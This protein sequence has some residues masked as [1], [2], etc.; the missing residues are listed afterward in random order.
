MATEYTGRR[1]A[2]VTKSDDTVLGQT[3]GLYVGGGDVVVR[4]TATGTSVTFANVPA[5]A[6]L[7]IE[8]RKV[9]AAT[10]A[11]NIVAIY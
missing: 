11:T 7:P 6:F 8:V 10:T 4:H 3:I 2:A 1:F 5:G 9:M